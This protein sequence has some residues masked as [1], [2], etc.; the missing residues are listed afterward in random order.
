DSLPVDDKTLLQLRNPGTIHVARMNGEV[1]AFILPVRAP[2]GYG[3]AIDAIVGINLDGSIAGVRVISHQETPGLGDKVELK[4][5][6][7][8]LSF[9]GRSLANTATDDWRVK[10]DKGVFDQF[11]GATITPRA[12]VKAVHNALQY[13]ALNKTTLLEQASHTA[14]GA[15]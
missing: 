5:S 9:N 11:T 2:D 3:G 15:E 6:P 10:K 4:K 1:V 14:T 8:V 13:F 12:M 7:W